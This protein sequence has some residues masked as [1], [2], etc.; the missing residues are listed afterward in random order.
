MVATC[1]VRLLAQ[2]EKAPFVLAKTKKE[3]NASFL[4]FFR[5]MVATCYVRLLAQTEKAPFVLAKTKKEANASF[6]AR[7]PA[8]RLGAVLLCPLSLQ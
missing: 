5:F 4:L 8:K 3:A 1:Y 2:T 6:F 7:L